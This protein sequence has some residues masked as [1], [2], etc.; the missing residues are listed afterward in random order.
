MVKAYYFLCNRI[1][2]VFLYGNLRGIKSSTIR[3]VIAKKLRHVSRVRT[4]KTSVFLNFVWVVQLVIPDTRRREREQNFYTDCQSLDTRIT[5][6][7]MKWKITDLTK[8]QSEHYRTFAIT[9][10]FKQ[11]K[12]VK[13]GQPFAFY[14]PIYYACKVVTFAT[15]PILNVQFTGSLWN[16][17]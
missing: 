15:F 10:P 6:T 5:T 13:E 17:C 11:F 8:S 4:G 16:I 9:I 1:F 3:R 2:S 12:K 7:T 14:C